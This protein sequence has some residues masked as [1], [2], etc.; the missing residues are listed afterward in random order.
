[1]EWFQATELDVVTK[2]P[3]LVAEEVEMVIQG[4][5]NTRP[6]RRRLFVFVHFSLQ[7]EFPL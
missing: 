6:F 5:K 2:R 4:N 1:M 3:K 7:R